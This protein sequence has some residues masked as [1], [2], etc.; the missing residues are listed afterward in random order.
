MG[1]GIVHVHAPYFYGALER[2]L[3]RSRL[4]RVAHVHLEE[5][6]DFS[7]V[8]RTPPELVMTCAQFLAKIVED[9]L[10]DQ[11]RGFTR[12]VAVPN[13]V[14]TDRFRPAP[15]AE[16]KQRVGAPSDRPL[17]LMLANLAP[18]KGHQ[19]T[20]QAIARLKSRGVHVNCWLAGIERD[21]AGTYSNR[22]GSLI[23][24]SGVADRVT[25]LGQRN[26]AP[27]LLR[28]ADFLVLPSTNE[29]LPLSILEA[30]ATRV[31]V[32]A[33][34][35]AGIPEV[36]HDGQTGFLIAADDPDGYAHRI[37]QLIANPEMSHRIA[38]AAYARVTRDHH[39][40][41]YCERVTELYDEVLAANS[42]SESRTTFAAQAVTTR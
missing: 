12:V 23:A 2:G 33:A 30:Q 14:D 27:D 40:Q 28:A 1:P 37:E 41:A 19:T 22:L 15:K 42:P 25:L 8:F 3:R 32:L 11:A 39:W 31:P 7:W 36:V 18:H 16:S 24:E 17:V 13:A 4:K 9:N 21:G 5:G 20:V 35:T 38:D 34:P 26:D 10:P 6:R 29:G